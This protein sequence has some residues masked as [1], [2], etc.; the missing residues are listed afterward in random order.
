M[1]FKNKRM[2]KDDNEQH[3]RTLFLLIAITCTVSWMSSPI[4]GPLMLKVSVLPE[5]NWKG[6]R[7]A[8]KADGTAESIWC[9]RCRVN[10]PVVPRNSAKT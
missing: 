4:S 1:C 10:L 2:E 7:V 8:I 9:V 3:V 5:W 6:G